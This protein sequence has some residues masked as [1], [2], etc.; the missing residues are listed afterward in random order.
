MT[1]RYSTE[2]TAAQRGEL[3]WTPEMLVPPLQHPNSNWFPFPGYVHM[4]AKSALY[5]PVQLAQ[6]GYNPYSNF[7]VPQGHPF[8]MPPFDSV[9]FQTENVEKAHHDTTASQP[10]DVYANFRERDVDGNCEYQEKGPEHHFR[11]KHSVQQ[12][13]CVF[14]GNAKAAGDIVDRKAPTR[15]T[16]QHKVKRSRTTF[17]DDQL[18]VLE[19]HFK[20]EQYINATQRLELAQFLG[21]SEAQIKIWWQ[22][23]RIKHRKAHAKSATR[24]EAD[25]QSDVVR[26]TEDHREP[27]YLPMP[28]CSYPYL[29][30][31]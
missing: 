21:L 27:G 24:R 11:G 1:S 13:N 17:N 14:N 3:P 31:Y 5:D 26:D 10:G 6:Y 15:S 8:A 29:H 4:F 22:N 19:E 30:N 18:R 20:G 2:H 9:G 7:V 23:R 12:Q 28:N 25:V 16:R